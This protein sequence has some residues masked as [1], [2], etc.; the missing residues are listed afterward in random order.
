MEQSP[1]GE[2]NRS[3]GTQQIPRILWNPMVHYR[4]HKYPPVPILIQLDQV[5]ALSSPSWRSI[6][7]L[8]SHLRM[9][10]QS[11]LFPSSSATKTLYKPLLSPY[12]LHAPA[13]LLLDFIT[14]TFII[15]IIIII[16]VFSIGSSSS[17]H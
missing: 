5:H 12:V 6:L 3:S 15:I 1:S 13:H 16:T 4:R 11:C 17:I 14:R 8:S 10:L 2:A 9:G 7:I